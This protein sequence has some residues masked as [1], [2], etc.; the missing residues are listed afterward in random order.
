MSVRSTVRFV[1]GLG[2]ESEAHA[3]TARRTVG[4]QC[5]GV[6]QKCEWDERVFLT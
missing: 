5:D 6:Q 1:A 3:Q 4:D 2:V